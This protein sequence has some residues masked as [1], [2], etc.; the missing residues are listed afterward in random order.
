M[1]K[2]QK[3]FFYFFLAL[4]IF[5]IF[6]R[7]GRHDML[8]DDG[9]YALRSLGYFDYVASLEQTTPVQWFGERP[10]WSYLGFHDHPFL[11]F[12]IQHIFFKLFGAG[13]IVSRLPSALAAL[14]TAIVI[15]FIGKR[16][17]GF[18]AGLISLGAL[19]LNSYFIWMGRVGL[20]ESVFTFFLCLGLYYF[21]KA[22]ETHPKYYIHSGLF[23]GLAFLTKYTFLFF[24]PG[25]VIYI[26]WRE[27]QILKNGK[28][29]T[30]AAVFFVMCLPILIYNLGMLKAR[31]HFDVQFSDLFGQSHND[32][33]I[34]TNRVSLDHIN[35]AG[36]LGSLIEGYSWPYF[37]VFALTFGASLFLFRKSPKFLITDLFASAFIF[38]AF[39]GG[40]E[41]WL[42][43]LSPFAALI[44]GLVLGQLWRERNKVMYT[45]LFAFACFFLFYTLNTNN[46]VKAVGPRNL[47]S[48]FRFE[49]YGYNQLDEKIGNLLSDKRPAGNFAGFTNLAWYHQIKPEAI[50]FSSLKGGRTEFRG[51]I[52]YDSNSLWFATIWGFERWKLY[53][54]FFIP[55]AD[56]FL[57]INGNERGREFLKSLGPTDLY[58]VASGEAVKASADIHDSKSQQ[59]VELFQK[60]SIEPEIVRDD[61]GR[62]AFYIYKG[63]LN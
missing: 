53:Q 26:L 41:R 24:V 18:R 44:I 57:Q 30:G 42:S 27:R 39:I 9:H 56:E 40:A 45:G 10:W 13:V 21:I 59:F 15:F 3:V 23:W 36:I 58:F 28:F 54:R 51:I 11:F 32:W 49:N 31:G 33:P 37:F 29:W 7:L 48:N 60:Q 35:P 50:N 47:Y 25:I 16:L 2:S 61:K 12:L 20:L 62:E 1:T 43:V 34:L 38:F 52:V 17:G 19:I 63:I 22:L 6:F 14:G 55:T 4:L 8:T 46:F 5:L